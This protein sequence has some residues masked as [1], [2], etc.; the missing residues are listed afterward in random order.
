VWPAAIKEQPTRTSAFPRGR[1]RHI[2][3]GMGTD[4]VGIRLVTA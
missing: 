3:L 1:A 4:V 2:R